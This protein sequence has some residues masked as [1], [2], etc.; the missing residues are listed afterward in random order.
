MYSYKKNELPKKTFEIIVIIPFKDIE[1]EQQ[2]AFDQLHKDLTV[3]GFRQ[4]KAPKTIAQKHI[5]QEEIYKK[6]LNELLPRLYDEIIK[7]ENI[8]PIISPKVNL[9]KAKDNTDWVI[10]F[11]VA[12]KPTIKL[13]DYKLAIQKVK[14]EN[15]KKDIWVPGKDKQVSDKKESV[16]K[17][18]IIN[19]ILTAILN[20]SKFEI[21]DIIIEEELNQRLSQLVDDVRKIG[22]TT[23][24]YLKSKN[25]TIDELKKRYQKEIEDMYKLEF[26]L[27]NIAD[28]ENIVVSPDE[29]EKLFTNITDL[30]EKELARKNS[31]YYASIVRKQKTLD[32][33][34]TL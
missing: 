3:S 23:D 11:T 27:S 1:I 15:K 22:L 7:K 32:F 17:E 14:S 2:K 25:L 19:E 26:A 34:M 5:S 9:E 4:G 12:E 30:K 10:I 8:H 24:A 13:G 31:Y 28:M 6:L 16:N 29:I 33:L 18:K 21:S 20:E